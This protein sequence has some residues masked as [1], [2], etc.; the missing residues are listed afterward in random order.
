MPAMTKTRSSC[1]TRRRSS[2]QAGLALTRLAAPGAMARSR[3]LP[4][5]PS[6][7]IVSTRPVHMVVLATIFLSLWLTVRVAQSAPCPTL[8]SLTAQTE[9]RLDPPGRVP[10][11]LDRHLPFR[12]PQ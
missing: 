9:N 4:I 6:L 2:L 7:G 11:A 5:S 3:R 12:D 1:G 8:A 10:L